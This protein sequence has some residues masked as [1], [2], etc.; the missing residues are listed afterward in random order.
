[1]QE[2]GEAVTLADVPTV[3][4][5]FPPAGQCAQPLELGPRARE[6][7]NLPRLG[8][9]FD[10]SRDGALEERAVVRD[11]DERARALGDEALEQLQAIEIEVVRRLVEQEDV[12]RMHE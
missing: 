1:M 8:L 3:G 10:D 2:P 11:Q 6:L 12:G 9:E 4:G 5:L 7:T